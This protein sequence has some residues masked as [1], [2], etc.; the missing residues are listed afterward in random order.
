[1][2]F[3]ESI[4]NHI[5]NP[6]HLP[7]IFVF[8]INNSP[9]IDSKIVEQRISR[10]IYDL[11][12]KNF[13]AVG[14]VIWD[15]QIF[16]LVH[17]TSEIDFC[18]QFSLPSQENRTHFLAALP[19]LIPKNTIDFEHIA[20]QLEGWNFHEIQVFY[21][22][23]QQYFFIENS[24]LNRKGEGPAITTEFVLDLLVAGTFSSRSEPLSNMGNKTSVEKQ[25]ALSNTLG[26]ILP[27]SL[28]C[29]V[30]VEERPWSV[31]KQIYR[32]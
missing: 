9:V 11:R 16:D 25:N 6:L 29:T 26:Q 22:A 30:A 21:Q 4:A 27:T 12:M 8:Q 18:F 24:F 14:L 20:R 13:P 10:M 31:V 23:C 2:D 7:G 5:K 1:M 28:G 3:N 15:S 19:S 17:L 32:E